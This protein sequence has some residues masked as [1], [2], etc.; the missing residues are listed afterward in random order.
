MTTFVGK[1]VTVKY[2]IDADGT[3]ETVALAQEVSV[4]VD[5]GR[6]DIKEIG[7]DA[8]QEFNWVG[9]GVTGSM[10]IVPQDQSAEY[11]FGELFDLVHPASGNPSGERGGAA[12]EDLILELYDGTGTYTVTITGV[13][14][15]SLSF[16]IGLEEVITFELPFAAKNISYAYA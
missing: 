12:K 15:G 9:I 8:I 16:A 4:E 13:G 1:D 10:T 14:F 6:Q 3:D 7:S 11:S 2:D 5:N